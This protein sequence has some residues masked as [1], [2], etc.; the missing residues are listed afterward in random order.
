MAIEKGIQQVEDK[1]NLNGEAIEIEIVNPESVGIE[2]E[3]GGIEIDFGGGP[4]GLESGFGENLAEI[5]DESE[6]DALGSQ[7]VS[8]FSA[9]K[10]SRADWEETYIKGLDQLGLTVDERTEPWPGACGVFHPLLSEAVIRFQSQA[11]SEIF[12]AEGPVKTKI[13]GTINDEK[14]KQANRIQEYMNYLLTEKMVEYRTETEKLLFSLPLAGSAFRKVYYDSN[15]GRPCSI[16][17]PAE[18]FVVSY[19][20]S[21]LL[22]CE[23]ATHVMKKT[24]N[25]IKKLM[26]SGF[27]KECDLPNPSPDIDEITDKY[28][29]LT[30]ESSV[31][32]DNDGRYTILEMQVDLDLAGFE[33]TVNGE[34]TGIALPYIVTVDKSSAKVL[35]IRRNYEEGDPKK[36]R[37]QHF[38]HYQYL[39]GI[40]F[41]GFGLIHMI[42]GLSRSATS[43]LRQL[44]DAGTLSNLPGGLKTRGLR[45]KGDD[46]P[47]MPGEFRDVDVPGGTIAEN[48]SFLPYKEPSPT[49]YQLLTTIVDE[50]RRFASLGDLKIAD[51]NN[52]APVGTTLALME[53]QMK[54]MGAIQSRLHAAMHKEFT[55][56][57]DIIRDFTP[58]EYPYYEDPDEFLKSEDF[59]GRVDVIPVSNPNAA[60][61]SQRIMQYQAALQLAQQAPDMY[62]MPELHRQMLEVLGIENVDKVIPNP[63]DFKPTDPVTENMNFLNMKPNKAF[64][65]QD[66]E[67]HI[68]VH[69]AG[70]QDPEFQQQSQQSASSGVIMMAVDDHIREHLAF[71]YREEI[72]NELGTPL[73]PIGEPLPADV[74]KRLSDLVAQAAEKLTARKQ[75]QAQQQQIQEQLED[76]IIQQ[77]NRELDIQEG[78]LMRKAKADEE[79]AA[80]NRARIKADVMTELKRIESDEK[81]EGAK[82]GQKI[83]DALLEAAME[84][85][86]SHSK[87]FAE[88]IRLAI[89][90][91]RELSNKGITE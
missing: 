9:D 4:T 27:F 36:R 74:E 1:K 23:R 80:A 91:Q 57:T 11:I 52:E 8:D 38:V 68:A 17:V 84:G 58:P 77:R 45:I 43:L 73:P 40:G 22:T 39:P 32:Y 67:A 76:P 66:H 61:M 64:E 24:E 85:E 19:G 56:L 18:D 34:P 90:I 51:M 87:E 35:A 7:I 75:Q 65:F 72:E 15:M 86:S 55:I 62:D 89:E 44:I 79:K 21:D 13:L 78:E 54:V 49:L 41:Y 59:D 63:D 70:M 53:R 60:T 14:E 20:A 6:L 88:G 2:T 48:I 10:E 69:M 81:I 26:Y 12:P 50:G 33:D 28:N 83:G 46:T 16:F 25:E 30:G 47:I 29:K 5:L 82:I 31:E 37:I 3:D 42:G 71:Q